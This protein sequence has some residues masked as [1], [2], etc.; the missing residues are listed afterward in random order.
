MTSEKDTENI[1]TQ[2]EGRSAAAESETD[3]QC[4]LDDCEE[5]QSDPCCEAIC[6]CC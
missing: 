6:C 1:S 3:D 2:D 4:Y 5:C